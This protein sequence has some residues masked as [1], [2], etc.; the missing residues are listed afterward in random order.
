MHEHLNNGLELGAA[1]CDAD[2]TKTLKA[3]PGRP[4]AWGFML[5]MMMHNSLLD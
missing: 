3:L 1:I 4:I 2:E 5:P